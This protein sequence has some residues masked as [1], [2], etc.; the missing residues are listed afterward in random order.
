MIFFCKVSDWKAPG[1]IDQPQ[2]K[3]VGILR[4]NSWWD[5]SF[6][7]LSLLPYSALSELFKT[8]KCSDKIMHCYSKTHILRYGTSLWSKSMYINHVAG[9]IIPRHC[10]HTFIRFKST[11]V[12]S[13][14]RVNTSKMVQEAFCSTWLS[15]FATYFGLLEMGVG[16]EKAWLKIK[17]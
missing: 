6:V 2:K 13:S 10:N 3:S 12:I 17:N 8:L 9:Y 7:R 5:L 4:E 11:E 14:L 15:G 16:R 1:I